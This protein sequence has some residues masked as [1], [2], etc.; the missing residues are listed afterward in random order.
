MNEEDIK[1]IINAECES[2]YFN[3]F[4]LA[5]GT[6]DVMI[7]LQKNGKHHLTLNTS[8]TVAK[9]L[10]NALEESIAQLEEKTGNKIMTVNEIAQKLQC[11]NQND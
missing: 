11:S 5:I 6:G 10:L 9:T 1:D 7:A 4:S 8:Y 3:G 2:I